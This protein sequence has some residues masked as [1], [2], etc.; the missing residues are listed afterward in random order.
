[1][2]D[3]GTSKARKRN[4]TKDLAPRHTGRVKGGATRELKPIVIVKTYDKS[5]A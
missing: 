5:S 2:G 3:K 1:M 4:T